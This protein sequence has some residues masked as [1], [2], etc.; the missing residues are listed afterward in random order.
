MRCTVT[1]LAPKSVGS[2]SDL[3]NRVFKL[4]TH[5]HNLHVEMLYF[6]LGQSSDSVHETNQTLNEVKMVFLVSRIARDFDRL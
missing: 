1:K 6:A 5:A 2:Y 3:G 4:I